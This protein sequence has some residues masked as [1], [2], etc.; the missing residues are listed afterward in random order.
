MWKKQAKRKVPATMHNHN[1]P[2]MNKMIFKKS[3]KNNRQKKTQVI[4]ISV[5]SDRNLKI[6]ITHIFKKIPG[7]YKTG[8]KMGNTNG[9]L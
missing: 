1:A 8:E 7:K 9:K 4:W 5:L 6:T 3:K 2:T